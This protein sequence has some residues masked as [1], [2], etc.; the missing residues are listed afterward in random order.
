MNEEKGI[1]KA[2]QA[3][4]YKDP[5]L[6]PASPWL[7]NTAP[8]APTVKAQASGDGLHAEWTPGWF[9]KNTWQWAVWVKQDGQWKFNVLS[10]DARSADFANAT[11]V[12]VSA[13]DRCGNE[14]KRVK[15]E[16]AK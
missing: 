11:A 5:A 4:P 15:A 2:L 3:G 13:V 12:C 6:V 16:I 14:S 1:G 8:A 7:D 10:G 9:D